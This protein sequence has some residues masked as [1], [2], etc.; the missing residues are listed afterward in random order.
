MIDQLEFF[1][2]LISSSV[3]AAVPPMRGMPGPAS[4]ARPASAGLLVRKSHSQ[5]DQSRFAPGPGGAG[6]RYRPAVGQFCGLTRSRLIKAGAP[7]ADPDTP[8]FHR[9]HPDHARG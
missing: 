4:S 2:R 9:Q 6:I 5:K 1:A 3:P 8:E 7:D